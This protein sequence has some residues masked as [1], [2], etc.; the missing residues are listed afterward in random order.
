[1]A[2]GREVFNDVGG[3][4]DVAWSCNVLQRGQWAA[5]DFLFSLYNSLECF[6]ICSRAAYTP[7]WRAVCWGALYHCPVQGHQQLFSVAPPEHLLSWKSL[8]CCF[9]NHFRGVQWWVEINEVP[10]EPQ[11][12][13]LFVRILHYAALFIPWSLVSSP[14]F[15]CSA[16]GY[17]PI[18]TVTTAL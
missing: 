11:T 17:S 18:T 8:F 5:S 3:S 2:G 6:L 7:S 13:L 9:L 10:W 14:W 4:A 16:A 1:M 12:H 15:L